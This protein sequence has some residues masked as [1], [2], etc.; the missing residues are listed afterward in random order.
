MLEGAFQ[1]IADEPVPPDESIPGVPAKGDL[2][3][4]EAAAMIA[5][6]C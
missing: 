5:R 3:G 1:L 6:A 4:L 2:A